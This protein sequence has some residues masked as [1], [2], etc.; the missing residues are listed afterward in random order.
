MK[1]VAFRFNNLFYLCVYK[2][3]SLVSYIL[4][5]VLFFILSPNVI[6]RFPKNGDKYFVAFVH[7]IIFAVLLHFLMQYLPIQEGAV[8]M[9]GP[10][11]AK[12]IIFLTMMLLFLLVLLPYAHYNFMQT[13]V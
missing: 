1:L 4:P 13:R 8:S 10:W 7:S 11:N 5:A 6:L 2:M 9:T 12:N 3:Y